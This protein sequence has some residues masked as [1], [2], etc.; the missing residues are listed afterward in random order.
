MN[1]TTLVHQALSEK[2]TTTVKVDHLT[3]VIS[4]YCYAKIGM[5][6]NM[7]F[8]I[9]CIDNPKFNREFD[10]VKELTDY[11]GQFVFTCV[12]DKLI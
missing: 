1:I 3:F 8:R 9:K 12:I 7:K 5:T 11:I 10:D 6:E 2:K 4:S